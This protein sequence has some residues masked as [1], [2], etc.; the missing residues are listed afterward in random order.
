MERIKMSF[1]LIGSKQEKVCKKISEVLLSELADLF[2]PFTT[3]L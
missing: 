2:L 1:H 3:C